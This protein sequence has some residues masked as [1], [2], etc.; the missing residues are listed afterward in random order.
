MPELPEVETIRQDLRATILGKKIVDFE[1]LA[2]KS[3]R[4][5]IKEGSAI[6]VG[7][8]FTEIDRIGKLLIFVLRQERQKKKYLLW[9]LKMTGQL[10]YTGKHREKLSF[11]GHSGSDFKADAGLPDKFT[12]AI[13]TFSG[14]F[15]LFFNDMRR[16]GYLALADEIELKKIKAKFGP[17]PLLPDFTLKALTE[18][19]KKRKKNI[20]AVLLDQQLIAGLGNIY[21]DESL[22]A[23]GVR[24]DRSSNSLKTVEIKRL[25]QEII[26]ILRLAVKHRGTTFNNYV[27]ASGRHGNFSKFLKV[28]GRGNQACP[29]C[30]GN[31]LKVKVAGRGTVYC[32]SCQK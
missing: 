30:G 1:V 26:R 5:E 18:I 10:I 12:R 3:L 6:L 29:R 13:F 28:Y 20:K 22:F 4:G 32:P 9:H 16:F 8:S 11:G 21:V 25:Y 19:F 7:N 17:E 24:P 2:K 15:Q 27:D 23:A 14:G 31:L